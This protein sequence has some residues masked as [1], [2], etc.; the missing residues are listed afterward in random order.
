MSKTILLTGTSQGIG[1]ALTKLLLINGYRVIG[2][3]T[4]GIDNINENNYKSFSLNLANFDSIAAFENNFQLDNIK[5]DI[6]I[7]NA[8]IGP[9]LDFDLPEE[10]SFKKTF[11]VNVTGTTFFTEQMLQYLNIGG[12]IVN[13]S[14]KMGSVDV[15]EKSDS[16]A[17]RMSKAALN[18][19]TKIL[20][21]R[22]EGKQLVASVHPGWVRTNIAKSNV[23]GRLSPEESAQK[24]F[25]FI[26][27]DFK[28]GIFWNVETEAECTW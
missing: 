27:S 12:K 6:L 1:H 11:D 9:D 16:V 22:L 21:N 18:M 19:Y 10:T 3:N 24:I 13:I 7:N 26:T 2:T 20:S 5:I 17:Y 4:T 14:S 23:N 28:T 8:G 25:Q 15:C